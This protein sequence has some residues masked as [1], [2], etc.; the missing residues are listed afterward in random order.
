VGA[1]IAARPGS[2]IRGG[3]ARRVP[4]QLGQQHGQILRAAEAGVAAFAVEDH[5]H[6]RGGLAEQQ[7][8]GD[9][10]RIA[11]RVAEQ[12]DDLV[13]MAQ[14]RRRATAPRRDARSDTTPP[15]MS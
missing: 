12:A 13:E 1:Q 15:P 3:R 6:L 10:Q 2:A 8:V 7:R 11:D 5:A 4:E 9:G 14:H